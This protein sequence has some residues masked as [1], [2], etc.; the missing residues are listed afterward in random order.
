MDGINEKSKKWY[1]KKSYLILG[2]LLCLILLSSALGGGTSQPSTNSGSANVYGSVNSAL[3][4]TVPAQVPLNKFQAVPI[5]SG[6]GTATVGRSPL[7]ND[8]YYTNSRGNQVHSPAYA[9][10]VPVGA[11][12]RCRDGTYSFSQSRRGTC[13]H[14]GGVAQWL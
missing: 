12:A 9:P 4:Q 8:D 1:Q 14:H 13:S 7:S 10:T 6:E 5:Q 3:E 2:V 11:Y